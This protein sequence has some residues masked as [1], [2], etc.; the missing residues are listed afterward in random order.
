MNAEAAKLDRA[1][2]PDL[3]ITRIYEAPR[4]LVWQALTVPEHL[5][6]WFGP[7]G[8]TENTATVDLRKGGDYTIMMARPGSPAHEAAYTIVEIAPEDRIVL[9]TSQGDHAAQNFHR[10][11]LTFGLEERGT[12]TVLTLTG[13]VLEAEVKATGPLAG[14]ESAWSQSLQRLAGAVGS[15]VVEAPQSEPTIVI[16]RIFKA[17]RELDVGSDVRSPNISS[18]GGDRTAPPIRFARWISVSAA[19]GGS[20]NASPTARSMSSRANTARS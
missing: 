3:V 12:Q 14:P 17:S 4:S 9:E 6:Q 16:S 7:H 10:V 18:T 19:N 20:S 11:R 15:L 1:D 8:F 2:H 5:A 13:H